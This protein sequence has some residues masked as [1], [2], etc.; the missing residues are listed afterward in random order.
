MFLS[1]WCQDS[2]REWTC[3]GLAGSMYGNAPTGRPLC[4]QIMWFLF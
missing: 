1:S 2:D 4:D 3:E